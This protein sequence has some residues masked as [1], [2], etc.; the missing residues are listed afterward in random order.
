MTLGDS[1]QMYSTVGISQLFVFFNSSIPLDCRVLEV[2]SLFCSLSSTVPLS[3]NLV[4]GM[5]QVFKNIY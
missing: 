4:F 1:D 5:S 3:P 2:W